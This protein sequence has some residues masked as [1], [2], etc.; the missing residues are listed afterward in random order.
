A[1]IQEGQLLASVSSTE[2]GRAL[3]RY[4]EDP[5][6]HVDMRDKSSRGF[7]QWPLERWTRL[8][9]NN[10]IHFLDT[11]HFSSMTRSTEGCAW[12]LGSWKGSRR[13]SSNTFRTFCATERG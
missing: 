11:H 5:R 7:Q 4:Y 10:P 3:Q 2:I 13:H 9:E 8:A 12:P 1:F 6:F